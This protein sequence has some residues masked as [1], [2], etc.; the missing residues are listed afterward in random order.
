MALT[1][2]MMGRCRQVF[3]EG[4]IV[5]ND[6]GEVADTG[7]RVRIPFFSDGV[8]TLCRIAS[9]SCSWNDSRH[10]APAIGFQ[11]KEVSVQFRTVGSVV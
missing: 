2:S 7:R 3:G 5:S 4:L 6:R 1:S 11:R 9:T 8:V 10:Y